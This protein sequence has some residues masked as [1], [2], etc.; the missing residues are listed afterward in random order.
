MKFDV[1]LNDV[2]KNDY[3]S[4]AERI[5][6]S[7]GVK[8]FFDDD[9]IILSYQGCEVTRH[10]DFPESSSSIEE[11]IDKMCQFLDLLLEAIEE[12]K[13]RHEQI[14]EELNKKIGEKAKVIDEYLRELWEAKYEKERLDDIY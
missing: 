1:T 14:V 6:H 3:V 10:F 8:A 7:G 11:K 4:I 13:K 2:V 5:L 12:L 9:R